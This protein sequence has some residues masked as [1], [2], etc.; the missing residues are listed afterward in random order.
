MTEYAAIPDTE[1]Q[2]WMQSVYALALLHKIRDVNRHVLANLYTTRSYEEFTNPVVAGATLVTLIDSAREAEQAW[3]VFTALWY[4]LFTVAA[5]GA[6]PR[7]PIFFSLDGLG[8]AMRMSDYRNQQFQPIHSHDLAIVRMFVDLLSGATSLPNGGAI[9]AA[10]S[11]SNAPRNASLEIAIARQLAR[12]TEGA[13]V[14]P[15]DPYCRTY[16][17]RVDAAMDGTGIEVVDVQAITK[18]EA[19]SLLEYWGASGLLRARVDEK[20]V[21]EKWMTGGNGVIAEME[22]AGLLSLRL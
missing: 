7:P 11:R 1:P 20:V 6:G 8:W 5:D 21:S 18:A 14:P 13:E 10:T 4:E 22:R 12:Q 15:R 16:D 17:E 19:R 2:I 9:V 3:P